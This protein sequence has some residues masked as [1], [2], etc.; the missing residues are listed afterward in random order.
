[1]QS[2]LLR[3][4]ILAATLSLPALPSMAGAA[5]RPLG[6]TAP[7]SAAAHTIT[8]DSDTRYVNVQDGEVVNFDVSGKTFTWD[9]DGSQRVESFDLNQV[10]PPGLLDHPVTAYV[11]PNP[12][13]TGG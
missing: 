4:A 3:P 6:E 7:P 12:L 11:A 9:F 13:Y 2:K 5:Q 8:I 1:M 10:A